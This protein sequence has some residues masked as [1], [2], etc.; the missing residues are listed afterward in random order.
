MALSHLKSW[1]TWGETHEKSSM[2]ERTRESKELKTQSKERR[3]WK[4]Q[5]MGAKK[6]GLKIYT[7]EVN[8]FTK[9]TTYEDILEEIKKGKHKITYTDKRSE[10]E[11]T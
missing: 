7:N 10:L 8:K 5:E 4:I 3:E 2:G 11:I 9:Q 1:R 6:S